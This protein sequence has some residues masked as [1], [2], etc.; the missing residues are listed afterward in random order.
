MNLPL[1]Q[2]R[3]S[4]APGQTSLAGSDVTRTAS[5]TGSQQSAAP[6]RVGSYRLLDRLGSGGMGEVYLAEQV[7]TNEACAEKMIRREFAGNPHRVTRFEREGQNTAR[8]SHPNIV[9]ILDSGRT[10]DGMPFLVME[11]LPGLSLDDL[12]DRTGPLPPAR[13]LHLLRQACAALRHAHDA[14]IIHRDVKPANLVV[15]AGDHLKL[16]DFGLARSTGE[17]AAPQE[18]TAISGTPLYMSPEQARGHDLD[19]RSDLYSLGA[20]AYALLTGRP[21]FGGSNPIDVL[22]AHARDEVAPPSQYAD[23]PA[24]LESIVLRCLAKDPDD[25][26]ADAASLETALNECSNRDGWTDTDAAR[27][28][29]HNGPILPAPDR[30]L[31]ELTS[32]YGLPRVDSGFFSN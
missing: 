21:P 25:R 29:D 15:T 27:W 30:E 17:P 3:L 28:W 18:P 5:T 10:A 12:L 4:A 7:G 2:A 22:I 20:V 6:A 8:L 24:D 9:G 19:A 32:P 16:V 1:P 13:A 23:V 11:Y 31:S 26:F 14:G